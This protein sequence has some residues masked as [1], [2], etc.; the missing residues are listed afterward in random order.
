MLMRKYIAVFVCFLLAVTGYCQISITP[1]VPAAGLIQKTQLW[2][3]AITNNS[4]GTANLR[5]SFVLTNTGTNAAV[6]IG[7]G[8]TF[9]SVN[10]TVQ[11]QSTDM[12]PI[13][14]QYPVVDYMD[15]DPD[16]FLPVGEYEICYTLSRQNNE[17][18][19]TIQ[20]T[21]VPI[22]VEPLSPPMLNMPLDED[23]LR[24]IYPQFSWLP[25]APL[26]IFSSLTYDLVIVEV[27]SD[28]TALEAMQHNIPLYSAGNLT[29]IFLNYPSSGT[30]LDTAKTYAWQVI[31]KNN[32]AYAAQS[33]VWSFRI[34]G[35]TI[36]NPYIQEDPFIKLSQHPDASIS[37]CKG[38]LKF[39]YNNEAD[40]SAVTYKIESLE[41][42]DLGTVVS[43]GILNVQFGDNYL[44]IPLTKDDRLVNERTYLM[45]LYNSRNEVWSMKFLYRNTSEQ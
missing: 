20:E 11:I 19:E 37:I 4:G 21:C 33:E 6:L 15:E 8:S 35:D 7:T 29:D 3:A 42:Y 9:T 17:V 40:D 25:P 28:Q 31:A 43:T 32:N 38:D 5:L 23:T 26:N 34:K 12:D 41:D 39:Y 30:S 13:Q 27:D 10:G 36:V 44:I 16:G 18:F 1:L 45:Q 2:G 14:Y 22:S 24:T